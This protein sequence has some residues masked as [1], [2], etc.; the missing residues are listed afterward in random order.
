MTILGAVR[1]QLVI[2]VHPVASFPKSLPARGALPLRRAQSLR[3]APGGTSAARRKLT[4]RS[5]EVSAAS[6]IVGP[7]AVVVVEEGM[8]GAV[9]VV[10]GDI[11]AGARQL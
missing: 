10:E 9:V 11:D 1:L 3:Q 8:S 2:P 6:A 5:H 4:L 7:Q